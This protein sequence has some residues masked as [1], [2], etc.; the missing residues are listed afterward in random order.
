[1]FAVFDREWYPALMSLANYIT[2]PFCFHLTT[3]SHYHECFQVHEPTC[4]HLRPENLEVIPHPN[5]TVTVL[6][7]QKPIFPVID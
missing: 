2:C 4:V 3:Y 6:V 1:M 7:H 5:G